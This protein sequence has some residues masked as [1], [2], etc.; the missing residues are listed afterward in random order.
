MRI[1]DE[2]I[3]ELELQDPHL[4]N[5]QFTWSNFRE[6]PICCRLDRFL[7]SRGFNEMFSYYRHEVVVRF[8]SDHSS[9]ILSTN[10]PSWGPIPFRFEKMWLQHRRFNA[11]VSGWWQQDT[12]YGRPGYKF[13]RKLRSLKRKL[14]G[15]NKEVFGDSRVEKKK[16]EKRIKELDNL[17]GSTK[18]NENLKEE[19]SKAKSDWYEIIIREEQATMM[20]SKFT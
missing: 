16:L 1:F 4:N 6:H 7:L 2:L 18:W 11:D 5:G 8:I 14:I 10:P 9:V 12:S 20:K 17:E 19:R 13:M 3:R 15:W